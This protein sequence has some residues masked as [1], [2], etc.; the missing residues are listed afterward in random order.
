MKSMRNIS[1]VFY[2]TSIRQIKILLTLLFFRCIQSFTQ[3]KKSREKVM[4]VY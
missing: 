4:S 3:G 1:E 2:E